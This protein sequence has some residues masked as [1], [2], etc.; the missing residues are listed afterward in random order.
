MH[1]VEIIAP[2]AGLGILS[3]LLWLAGLALV[4]L[5]LYFVVRRAVRDALRDHARE[6]SRFGDEGR[7]DGR[8]L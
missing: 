6:R 7:F 3:L 2:A 8:N 1:G 5:V 4:A